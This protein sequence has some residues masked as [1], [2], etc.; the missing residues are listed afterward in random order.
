MTFEPR[1]GGAVD[2]CP[3]SWCEQT[4]DH[5]GYQRRL[6]DEQTMADTVAVGSDE[7]LTVMRKANSVMARRLAVLE[8]DNAVLVRRIEE[9]ERMQ[10]GWNTV[11]AP[12]SIAKT[13]LINRIAYVLRTFYYAELSLSSVQPLLA[14]CLELNPEIVE[15]RR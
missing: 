10:H 2:K 8:N 7:E 13:D 12:A 14:L 3:C 6:A 4:R 11:S 15:Q 1:P 5:E 9:F